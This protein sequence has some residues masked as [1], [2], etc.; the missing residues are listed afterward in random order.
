VIP[1]INTLGVFMLWSKHRQAFVVDH[2]TV[3]DDYSRSVEYADCCIRRGIANMG[4]TPPC[5]PPFY[6]HEYKGELPDKI[7]R[8]EPWTDEPDR[9]R[10]TTSNRRYHS[11]LVDAAII[12]NTEDD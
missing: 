1:T 9:I 5:I 4:V 6:T 3:A 7:G 12:L 10:H 8:I 2:C 11:K